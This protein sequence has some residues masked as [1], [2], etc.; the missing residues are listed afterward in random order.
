V[1]A[2]LEP[3]HSSAWRIIGPGGGGAQFY[4]SISPHDDQLILIACD[5]SGLYLSENGGDLWRIINL[6]GSIRFITFDPL[7][8]A[9]IYVGTTTGV[10]RSED[11]G[12]TW[13]VVIPRASDASFHYVDDEAEPW[14]F[15]NEHSSLILVRDLA[16]DPADSSRLYFAI[17]RTLYFSKDRGR[18]YKDVADPARS[19]YTR[20]YV[21]P[22]SPPNN[23][24][25]YAVGTDWVMRWQ[26]GK[27]RGGTPLNSGDAFAGTAMAFPAGGQPILYGVLPVRR[28]DSKLVGGLV[29][30]RD[31][32]T[33]QSLNEGI[34]SH[35]DISKTLPQFNAIA[36]APSDP[37]VL[38][39]DYS[40]LVNEGQ[41][42]EG[43]ARSSDG[44]KTWKLIWR[45]STEFATN[46]SDAW[47]PDRF[48]ADWPGNHF[49]FAVSAK[50]PNIC[51]ATDSGRTVRTTDGGETWQQVY[52]QCLEDG[53][54]T[55]TGMDITS[56]YGVHFDP[57]D[58]RRMFITFTDIG[59]FRSENEGRSWVPSNYG[60]PREWRNTTYWLEFDPEVKGLMWSVMSQI[61]DL[62]RAKMCCY[63][64][65]YKGG[66]CISRDGGKT[67]SG[68]NKGM[69]ETAATHILLDPS[70]PAK[71]RVLYVTGYGTGVHKS[72][73]GGITWALKNRGIE[74]ENPQAWRMARDS[75]GV[76]YLIV[77]RRNGHT[78]MVDGALYRSGDGAETWT[79]VT[80]PKGVNG[81]NGI[82]IDPA[83]PNRLYLANW[84]RY[85]NNPGG[86]ATDGGVYVSD[87]GGAHWSYAFSGDQ[88]IFDITI[89]PANTAV[90]Y[91]A[92]HEC[93]VWRSADHGENWSRIPGLNFKANQRVIPDPANPGMIYVA[94]YGSCVW[95][96][97]AEG[98]PNAVEDIVTP[99]WT[100]QQK[101]RRRH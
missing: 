38:Y 34:L 74:G 26:A 55:S 62:P 76:L 69:S 2:A 60:C 25:V 36:T 22:Q 98:D 39:L 70:S 46:V 11:R 75:H 77:A 65:D 81:P 18:S 28:K 47:I 19:E 57:F 8:P 1:K 92:G 79:R 35:A 73:D 59:L 5:M 78:V 86:V 24:A 97:P 68:S 7:A 40:D 17:E 50:N 45:D 48:E 42:C 63:F 91:A 15:D 66:V 58:R 95:H 67:W 4:P 56:T 83:R 87:D 71:A 61:H 9:V 100:F 6:R 84:G 80:L 90:V 89:D 44:G 20:L 23:R 72:M 49:G 10:M 37:S 33:W 29:A 53:T 52:S 30:T 85:A 64:A 88:H 21:D 51:V 12:R 93:A 16:I 32:E 82:A 54:Y 99:G 27:L 94:T 41:A 13:N 14:V 96:G 43:V 101:E 31:C 3:P